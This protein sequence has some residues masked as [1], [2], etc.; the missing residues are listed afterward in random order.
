MKKLIVLG[1]LLLLGCEQTHHTVHEK[2]QAYIHY[3]KD[4]RTGVCFAG[5]GSLQAYS[6]T[7]AAVTCTPD[8][9]RLV[10]AWPDYY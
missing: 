2:E 8:I 5:S 1:A 7:L 9:E 3:Y 10:E 6:A 4:T